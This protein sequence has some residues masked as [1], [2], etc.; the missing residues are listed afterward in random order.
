[1]KIR[2][3]VI[4]EEGDAEDAT[5]TLTD[6]KHNKHVLSFE[7]GSCIMPVRADSTQNNPPADPPTD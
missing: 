1:M 6:F 7:H 5:L 4:K 2:A 3:S